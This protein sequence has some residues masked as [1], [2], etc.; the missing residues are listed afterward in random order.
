[1]ILQPLVGEQVT[2]VGWS[3]GGCGGEAD[4]KFFQNGI[5]PC[6]GFDS[7]AFGTGDDT[8]QNGGSVA[9]LFASH[10][11][12]VF[13]ENGRKLDHAFGEIVVDR[14]RTVNHRCGLSPLV[15]A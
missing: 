10:K 1:M 2:E 7:A 15:S 4:G 11:Q 13:S 5:E 14:K 9:T 3:C 6:P 12:T 8:Q